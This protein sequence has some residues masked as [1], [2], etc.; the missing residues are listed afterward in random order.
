MEYESGEQVTEEHI[1]KSNAVCFVSLAKAELYK[2]AA[3]EFKKIGDN[4]WKLTILY[5]EKDQEII[6]K[7]NK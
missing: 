4:R 3:E 7:I 1:Y 6:E 2:K 5:F